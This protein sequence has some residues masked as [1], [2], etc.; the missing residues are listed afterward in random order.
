MLDSVQRQQEGYQAMYDKVKSSLGSKQAEEVRNEQQK[1]VEDAR[2]A[3]MDREGV[4]EKFLRICRGGDGGMSVD[5][6]R[7]FI[8]AQEA[9]VPEERRGDMEYGQVKERTRKIDE[10]SESELQKC[11]S[12]LFVLVP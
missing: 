12:L 11:C 3:E 9:R 7:K 10:A 2:K 1:R 5:E 4:D 8:K 6:L